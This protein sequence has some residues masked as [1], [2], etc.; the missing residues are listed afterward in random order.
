MVILLFF[1]YKKLITTI[2]LC[3]FLFNDDKIYQLLTVCEI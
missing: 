1:L 3:E 2:V